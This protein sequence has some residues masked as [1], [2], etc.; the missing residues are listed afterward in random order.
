M[1]H[2]QWC[3]ASFESKVSYQI[4]CSSEC[5][6]SATKEKIA[7]RYAIARI[8]KRIKQTRLCKGCGQ[9]LSAYNDDSICF[10]CMVD[11]REVGKT[12]REIKGM[13][14]GKDKPNKS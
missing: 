2:C 10:T 14:D 3:D 12:L 7:E 13:A 4:Y 9:R 8:N 6:E 1:K 5:R 11:P